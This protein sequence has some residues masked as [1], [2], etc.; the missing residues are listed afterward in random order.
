M[1]I[2]APAEPTRKYDHVQALGAL[3]LVCVV[4]RDVLRHPL[5][6]AT[7]QFGSVEARDLAILLRPVGVDV[8]GEEVRPAPSSDA[9]EEDGE[10]AP[11]AGKDR[12]RVGHAWAADLEHRECRLDG[13]DGLNEE[14]DERVGRAVPERRVIRLVPDL[15]VSEA[16]ARHV[17]VAAHDVDGCPDPVG[18]VRRSASPNT[19]ELGTD[20]PGVAD[21]EVRLEPTVQNRPKRSVALR[22]VVRGRT[23][24][25][26]LLVRVHD[27][28]VQ[29][30]V[31]VVGSDLRYAVPA[32]LGSQVEPF[33]SIEHKGTCVDPE[34]LP[35]SAMRSSDRDRRFDRLCADEHRAPEPRQTDS[36]RR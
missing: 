7:V 18:T 33:P 11:A 23:V 10:G 35:N 19:P 36:H 31:I 13:A 14:R 6:A 17:P 28:H 21:P 30:P 3:A 12:R 4:L 32:V 24:G 20:V 22:E 9:L 27:G 29:R 34:Q 2:A 15:H 25:V 16:V 1:T 8:P 5:E 26:R